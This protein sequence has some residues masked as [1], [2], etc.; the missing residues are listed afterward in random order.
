MNRKELIKQIRIEVNEAAAMFRQARAD[1]A[2][3]CLI[4]AHDLIE[5]ELKQ[6]KKVAD[7][8]ED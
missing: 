7:G 1:I 3:A 5:A 2:M 8:T 6:P 4:R